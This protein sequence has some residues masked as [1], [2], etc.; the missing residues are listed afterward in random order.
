MLL[1]C[2]F[3][4]TSEH[5][6]REEHQQLSTC[7]DLH[8]RGAP[9]LLEREESKETWL[10]LCW[11]DQH[12]TFKITI[13]IEGCH[14]FLGTSRTSRASRESGMC[15]SLPSLF[16]NKSWMKRCTSE[17]LSAKASNSQYLWAHKILSHTSNHS[18][19][20]CKLYCP[21]NEWIYIYLSRI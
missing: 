17:H 9:D 13:Y 7:T 4:V 5:G 3:L 6:W 11:K 10:V 12:K 8:H 18:T 19:L 20:C 15:L 1:F 21:N 16:V 2:F 14:I